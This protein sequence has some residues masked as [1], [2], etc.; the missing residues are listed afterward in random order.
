MPATAR[1]CALMFE[2]IAGHDPRDATSSRR[3]APAVLAG[4]EGPLS[5]LRLA[6]PEDYYFDG[7]TPEVKAAVESAARVLESRGARVL[8][9]RLPDPAGI[10]DVSH[11]LA[12]AESGLL[13]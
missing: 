12:R 10:V 1:D 6:L 9:L 2:L 4:L 3:P 8:P 7:V 5:G 13:P 11:V